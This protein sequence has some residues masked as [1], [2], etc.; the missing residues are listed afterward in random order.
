VMVPHPDVPDRIVR[1]V[2]DKDIRT[3]DSFWVLAV[4]LGHREN[5]ARAWQLITDNW[6]AV[7]GAMPPTNAYRMT[8]LMHF[9]SEPEV[10]AAIRAWFEDHEIPGADKK[11]AQKLEQLEVRTRLRE[12]EGERLGEALR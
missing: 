9:R 10:A 8:D 6:D 5:G 12:R 2:I 3:Q 4:L 7:L 11:V 1:M